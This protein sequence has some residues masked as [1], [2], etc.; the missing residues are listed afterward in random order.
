[1]LSFKRVSLYILVILLFSHFNAYSQALRYG[2]NKIQYTDFQWKVLSTEHLNIYYYPEMKEL[3][4]MGAFFAEESYRLLENKFNHTV[5]RKIPLILYSSHLHFQQ[6]N[7]TPYFMP[8]GVGGFYESL[9]G[10]V[11][12]PNTGNVEEFRRVIRHELTHV[13]MYSKL[14]W[15]Q[16]NLNKTRIVQ[17]PLWFTEGLAEVWSSPEQ[18]SQSRMVIADQVLEG[19]LVPLTSIYA[20]R[21]SYLM[22][23]EGES[24]LRYINRIYGDEKLLMIL[25]NFYRGK[26]FEDVFK[27]VLGKS[28]K[29]LNEEWVYSLKKK[30]YPMLGTKEIPRMASKKITVKGFNEVP[31]FYR[32]ED[33]DKLFYISNTSGYTNIVSLDLPVLKE[34]ISPEVVVKAERNKQFE[35]IHFLN[36]SID[37]N[38]D[39]ILA[40]VSK[41]GE[42]DII[43]L[44]D[45]SERKIINSFKFEDLVMIA[46]PSWSNDKRR[47]AFSALHKSGHYDIYIVDIL[48]NELTQ[49]T[50]D[51]YDDKD[52]AW[53]P[54]DRSLIFSSARSGLEEELGTYNLFMYT[55]DSKE[56]YRLTSGNCKDASPSWSEDGKYLAYTSNSG[57]ANNI[58]VMELENS[59]APGDSVIINNRESVDEANE[60]SGN[61][62]TIS[63]IGYRPGAIRKIT[64]FTTGAFNPEW[65]PDGDIYFTSFEKYGHQLRK[66]EEIKQNLKQYPVDSYGTVLEPPVPWELG[67]IKS[68]DEINTTPYKKKYSLDV[69]QGQFASDPVWG[70]TG[71][72]QFL[73]SDLLGNDNY[74]LLVHNNAQTKENLFRS[75]NFSFARYALKRRTNIGYGLF[76]F[77]GRRYNSAEFFYSERFYGGFLN[78]RYPLSVFQRVE[79]QTTMG[80]SEKDIMYREMD[81]VALLS[82]N[83]ISFIRDNS[84]WGPTGPLDGGRY[85][86]SVGKTKDISYNNVNYYTYLLDLRR[87][88]RMTLRSSFAVRILTMI[89]K[90]KEAQRFFIGGSWDLR[91][92]PRWQVWGQEVNFISTEYRF[93]FI[94]GI[95]VRFPFGGI[96]FSSIRGALFFDAARI[97][98]ETFSDPAYLGSMGLGFR[99]SLGG[100]L[101]LRYDIGRRFENDFAKISKNTYSQFFFGWDF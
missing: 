84:I 93:P 8:E 98:D 58:Y 44:Y 7:T 18:D 68:I 20:I 69:A 45:V 38:S 35:V 33:G 70:S 21:G 43:Y 27:L 94:D 72:A 60:N 17:P 2:R 79:F 1:M 42:T 64:N 95:G 92:Y 63:E 37:I 34:D 9:K 30:Y 22:Y 26:T 53:T 51:L 4:E 16:K 49:L 3:A 90:G 91:G 100:F 62:E 81:R 88:F 61:N 67:K 46:S 85:L 65:T 29:Q 23:K 83:Y 101:V 12:I 97:N 82:G 25:E 54:D 75:F 59:R 5:N 77:A 71:G 48:T 66:I 47:L 28:F 24:L 31:V 52:P 74:Y 13:F 39:G 87:Y 99:L 41:S 80:R 36:R 78:L 10:R 40:F 55:V 14:Y 32:G 6:T 96:G 50:D 19:T 15:V 73:F 89:N 57:G 11:V 76:H 56:K 86:L